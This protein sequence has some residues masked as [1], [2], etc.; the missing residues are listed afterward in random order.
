MTE[1]EQLR[2]ELTACKAQLAN[3]GMVIDRCLALLPRGVYAANI[4]TKLQHLKPI[5]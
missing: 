2:A 3:A 5:Q 1:V 4:W